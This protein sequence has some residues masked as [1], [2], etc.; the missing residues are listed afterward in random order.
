MKRS[1]LSL[2]AVATALAAAGF[3]STITG[4]GPRLYRQAIEPTAAIV[5]MSFNIRYGTARDGENSWENRREF[6][7]DVLREESPDLIGTQE[8][9]R[10]QLD[11]IDEAL[12]GYG[13]IGVG[14]NDGETAGEYAAILYRVNRFQVLDSGTFWF[15]ETPEVPGSM[16]WGN[17]ITRICTWARFNDRESGDTFYLYNLHLDHQSQMSRERSVELLARR[18]ADRDTPDRVVVTGDFNADE[19]N[20]AIRYLKGVSPRAS[21]RTESSPAPPGLLDSWRVIHP[22][23]LDFATFNGFSDTPGRGKID[24]VLV[25]EEWEVLEA[26]IVRTSREGR[27][28]SDHF[29]VTARLVFR[30]LNR[31][32]RH[33]TPAYGSGYQH[34]LVAVLV[35]AGVSLAGDP[36]EHEPDLLPDLDL[37]GR[38]V[39]HLGGEPAAIVGLDDGD[40]KRNLVREFVGGNPDHREGDDRAGRVEVDRVEFA[41][42]AFGTDQP[43]REGKVPAAGALAGFQA[44]PLGNLTG[45]FRCDHDTPSRMWTAQL[46]PDPPMLWVSP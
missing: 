10:F 12:P 25:D 27:Y 26:K 45:V 22:D 35:D 43:G 11:Y 41:A 30:Q 46:A 20:R 8:G 14:L 29:P 32:S 31:G 3:T 9:L 24:Y 5:V 15:S 36:T 38:A 1:L 40:R 28:P 42:A 17:T 37:F 34:R 7:V 39:D 4:A 16:H 21:L 23:A 13:E 2:L 33:R 6:L 18:M 44:V 19:R